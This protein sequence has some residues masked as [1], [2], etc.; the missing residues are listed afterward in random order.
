MEESKGTKRP[1]EDYEDYAR[2]MDQFVHGPTTTYF[3]QL[4]RA[5]ITLPD[6]NTIT[7]DQIQTT[8]WEMIAGLARLR[9]FVQY[10]NHLNDRDLYS[11]LWHTHLRSETPANDEIGFTSHIDVVT[12]VDEDGGLLFFKYYADE[13]FRDLWRKDWPDDPMPPHEEPP[14]HRDSIL[15]RPAY[16]RGPEAREWLHANPNAN[17]FA[18]H[19]FERTSEAL[20]FVERLYAAGAMNVTIDNITCLPQHRWL[21]YADRLIVSLP[22]DATTRSAIFSLIDEVSPNADH[23]Q[24]PADDGSPLVE[25]W[26][27]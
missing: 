14:Y 3:E 24:S 17:A 5:G 26:W 13:P 1:W 20:S 22:T 8:L 23:T 12:A 27:N 11:E 2:K 6:P 19:R 15:P 10:T 9:V 18:S 21:P 16:D 7:D 4:V 25:V